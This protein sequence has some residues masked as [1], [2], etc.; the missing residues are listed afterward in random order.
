M[1]TLKQAGLQRVTAQHMPKGSKP[2]IDLDDGRGIT[3]QD[4]N[5]QWL[6]ALALL[7][8]LGDDEILDQTIANEQV[9][10]RLFHERAPEKYKAKHIFDHC[11]CSKTG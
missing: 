1:D 5:D 2:H 9:I 11:G 8:T 7:N 6:E 10:Y 4:D 3:S